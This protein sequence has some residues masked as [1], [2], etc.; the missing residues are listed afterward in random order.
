MVL[1]MSEWERGREEGEAE[2]KIVLFGGFFG[3]F[4]LV[5]F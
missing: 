1:S 5:L 2:R 3:S 4:G